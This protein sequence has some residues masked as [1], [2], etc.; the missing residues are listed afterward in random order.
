LR[1][2]RSGSPLQRL[3]VERYEDLRRRLSRRLGSED[4]AQETLQETYVRIEGIAAPEKLRSPLSYLMRTALNVAFDKRWRRAPPVEALPLEE[5]DVADGD[6]GPARAA[7]GR[8]ELEHLVSALSE[9]TERQRAILIAARLEWTN[10][11]RIADHLGIS[12]RMVL[13]ELK[14]ALQHCSRRL[15]REDAPAEP[16]DRE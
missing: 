11:P 4:E 3:L 13:I 6:P 15:S 9:L 10:H 12:R 5:L 14:R 8:L 2:L 7:E 16:G 1:D